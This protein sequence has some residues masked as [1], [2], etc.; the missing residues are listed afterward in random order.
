MHPRCA[1]LLVVVGF[2]CF[3]PVPA[4]AHCDSPEGPVIQDARLALERGDPTLV[5]KWVSPEHEGEIKDAFQAALVVREEGHAA[6]ALADRYFFETLVR[7]HRAGEGEPYTG[8]KPSG[9]VDPGILAADK[10]LQ[11]GSAKDLARSMSAAVAEAIERR[12]QVAAER[13]K[14]AA[15]SVEAGRAYV[16]A[17]VD[18][19]HFVE[20]VG[21]LTS[22]GGAHAHPSAHE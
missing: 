4:S 12:F 19:V 1:A 18:Y 13:K 8:L 20:S 22:T 16:E 9:T 6:K 11:S 2:V 5:L 7:V 14:H 3:I 15:D 21:R 17:Y 10:G